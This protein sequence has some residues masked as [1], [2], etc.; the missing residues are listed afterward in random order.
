[1][2]IMGNKIVSGM[3]T[4]CFTGIDNNKDIIFKIHGVAESVKNIE[5]A[6]GGSNN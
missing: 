5:I 6:A 2:R 1:M 3:D 4:M